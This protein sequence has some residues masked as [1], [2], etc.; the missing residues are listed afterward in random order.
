MNALTVSDIFSNLEYYK[1]HYLSILEHPEQYFTPVAHAYVQV[2]PLAAEQL[3]LG[4][5]LQLWLG[6]KWLV[7]SEQQPLI[8]TVLREKAKPAPEF[9]RYVYAL[10]GSLLTGKNTAQ[11]WSNHAGQSA[12]LKVGSVF[13]YYCVFKSLA[14]PQV[15][16][17]A[18]S[19]A[20]KP[21]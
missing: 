13:Q 17:S 20:I 2:W 3:Y 1:E 15:Q 16:K 8:N 6:E 5:L 21:I 18:L 14:R 9:D 4:D 7:N 12:E 11:A 10:Q 19:K